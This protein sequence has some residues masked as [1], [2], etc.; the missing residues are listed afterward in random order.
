MRQLQGRR[1][2]LQV[3]VARLINENLGTR[4][5]MNRQALNRLLG[6]GDV[7]KNF[8]ITSYTGIKAP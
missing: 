5:Y 8:L 7:S 4:V 6:N 1:R 2:V 3:P